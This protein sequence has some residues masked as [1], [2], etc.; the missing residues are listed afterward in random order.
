MADLI[1]ASILVCVAC[2]VFAVLVRRGAER[3]SLWGQAVAGAGLV[4]VAPLHVVG[5]RFAPWLVRAVPVSNL[6]VL[7]NP[8]PLVAAGLAGLVGCHL[9]AKPA[10]R[11]L[12][13]VLLTAVGAY[14]LAGR[15]RPLADSHM[16]LWRNGV[17]IQS[18]LVTC[19]AAAAATL[20][21]A[22]GIRTTEAEMVGLCRV[23]SRGTDY[24]GL[25]RG[26]KLRTR[27]TQWRVRP[28]SGD[29]RA[30]RD[31][32]SD[33]PVVLS[34]GLPGMGADDPRYE[35]E[36]GWRRGQAHTVVLFGFGREGLVEIGDPAVGREHWSEEAVEVLW[37]GRGF[38][39]A[40][41]HA[42]GPG[43]APQ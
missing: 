39:L 28:V 37:R 24:L 3:L 27:G 32:C 1:A 4:L 16:D 31:A 5:L 34:V 26:L 14:S 30:L 17:C 23:T 6:V 22:H 43:N 19:S 2:V 7:S 41:E 10:R 33:G 42:R 20:L 9:A 38:R 21:R 29:L 40:R 13:T 18:S 12:Y 11:W 15:I 36:W 8:L 25:C 35:T